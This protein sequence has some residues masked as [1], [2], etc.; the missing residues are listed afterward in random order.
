MSA[1]GP[2]VGAEQ[3]GGGQRPLRRNHDVVRAADFAREKLI[4]TKAHAFDGHRRMVGALLGEEHVEADG[5]GSFRRQFVH[6][7]GMNLA[8]P[9]ESKL[10][11]ERAVQECLNAVVGDGD[12]AEVCG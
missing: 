7:S 10:V 1:D 3:I 11:R 12:Q 8:R 4:G 2:G 6:E 5:A 9:M